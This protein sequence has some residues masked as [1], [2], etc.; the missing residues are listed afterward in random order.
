[1]PISDRPISYNPVRRIYIYESDIESGKEKIIPI[2]SLSEDDQK[3]L[4]IKR[5][6]VLPKDFGVLD[7][8][9]IYKSRDDVIRAIKKDEPFGLM[10]VEAEISYLR[11]YLDEIQKKNWKS[12]SS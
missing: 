8:N 5:W 2:D 3:K 1:M 9:G 11:E 12:N 7:L 6:R 10:T 4:I